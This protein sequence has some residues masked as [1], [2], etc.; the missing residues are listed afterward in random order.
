MRGTWRRRLGAWL[1]ALCLCLSLLPAA[2][3]AVDDDPA[4]EQGEPFDP[5]EDPTEPVDPTPP[6]SQDDGFYIEY[7][8]KNNT[9]KGE[10]KSIS[11]Y[12]EINPNITDW[13]DKTADETW[14]VATGEVT[15]GTEAEPQRVTV[16]GTVNLILK[17]GCTLTVH[18]GIQVA[19][20]S[21]L[22]I[23]G[24]R[25]DSGKL[26]ASAAAG[27][28]KLIASAAAGSGNAGIG[29]N[30]G[31]SCGA[32][33]IHG[34]RVTATGGTGTGGADVEGGSAGIGSGANGNMSNSASITISGKA[35]VTA[36]AG[37]DGAAIGTGA[38]GNMSSGSKDSPGNATITIG[39]WAT[40]NA[41]ASGGGA[42]IGTGKD[43]TMLGNGGNAS[44]ITIQEA[45]TVNATANGTGAAIGSGQGDT[46]SNNGKITISATSSNNCPTVTA[47]AKDGGAAIGSGAGADLC[48][49]IKI[50]GPAEVN[51]TAS[52]G[53]AAIGSGAEAGMQGYGSILIRNSEAQ[54]EDVE[55]NDQFSPQITATVRNGAAAVIGCGQNGSIG[56]A[57]D[58][59]IGGTAQLK[60]WENNPTSAGYV[61]A[62]AIGAGGYLVEEEQTKV[63]GSIKIENDNPGGG[64]L[65]KQPTLT[66]YGTG[67][68]GPESAFESGKKPTVSDAVSIKEVCEVTVTAEAG[69]T[70]SG[71]GT[72]QYQYQYGNKGTVD[73]T[74]TV[75][76]TPN[77]GCRFVRWAENGE[78]VSTDAAYTF[79]AAG[80]RVLT[81]EFAQLPA[82][83]DDGSS[84]PSGSD[85]EP[86]Y[87]PDVERPEGG[88][89]SVSP[90]NPE[91]GDDVT[92]TPEPEEGFEVD[93]V[94]VTDRNGDEVEVTDSGD[95]T[96]TFEQPRGRV[97]ISVTF[98]EIP[99]EPLPFTDVPAGAWYED[100]VRYVYENGLMTGVSASRF[101]P[102]GTTTR[103][104]IV[105]IL[106]RLS[107]S[108]Q[109]NYPM[110]F[111]DVSEGDYYAQAV[112]W[113]VSAG[114]AAG[115]GDGRFG[116]GDPITREQLAVM[117]WRYAVLYG[118]DVSV[119]ESTNILSYADAPDVSEYA[120]PA[121][122]W[123]CGAGII[124]GTGGGT[125]HPQ[126]TATRA[127]AAAMLQRF[128]ELNK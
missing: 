33:T 28:G 30:S 112:R 79:S 4:G 77:S 97:T 53:G 32:I 120:I 34:G 72:H 119:G 117:L 40:V 23:Y 127:Q 21:T 101:D 16:N 42:A 49:E 74:I 11:T 63:E 111:T 67:E 27:S 92:I 65:P 1:L 75:T 95:G 107:G 59:T 91:R 9:L 47:E 37:G 124:T 123:A 68:I 87:L 86:T 50:I 118:Y 29:G 109:V 61:P 100:A 94:T 7:T 43:G 73:F 26:I 64:L 2:A 14:Y 22:T 58:I 80:N 51:A 19:Q 55:G 41:T 35:E 99:P 46:K 6:E 54:T 44:S 36:T 17:D 93:E 25:G 89:V 12:T 106:W 52:G 128:C 103:G 39:D 56:G 8:W 81:A 104:Q 66:L 84:R 108:P 102:D 3:L 83:S 76:A 48:T 20:G 24:Q 60:L 116:P 31:Q 122:Q 78:T 121:L 5:G 82:P 98:R 45:A 62:P 85:S 13:G 114:I 90:R 10:E 96:W 125:L 88:A 15:I 126:G 57:S 71:G 113:A 69:G 110:D 38:G 18:G 115:Y 105:T 70:V